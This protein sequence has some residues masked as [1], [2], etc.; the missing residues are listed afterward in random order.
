METGA[1]LVALTG[2]ALLGNAVA[3]IAALFAALPFTVQRTR[4]L[5]FGA[6]AALPLGSAM[7][8]A[9]ALVRTR[10][11]PRGI[12]RN[13]YAAFAGLPLW[14][15]LALLLP[16]AS[17]VGVGIAAWVFVDALRVS[18]ALARQA[19]SGLRQENQLA[20][21]FALVAVTLNVAL[22]VLAFAFLALFGGNPLML[23]LRS[24]EF[25]LSFRDAGLAVFLFSFTA[26]FPLAWAQ[27]VALTRLHELLAPARFSG[28]RTPGP[29][30]PGPSLP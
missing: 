16:W 13:V 7:L 27:L 23:A 8:G 12:V 26:W 11:A 9:F 19:D 3:T 21:T 15:T 20:R 4:L 18:G 25:G 24:G 6:F 17:L 28:S 10:A 14:M 1:A 29:G 2:Y 22:P 30:M 5:R